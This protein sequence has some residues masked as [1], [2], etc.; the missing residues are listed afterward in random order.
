S[1]RPLRERLDAGERL[2]AA[3][4]PGRAGRRLRS[5]IAV[6]DPAI[7]LARESDPVDEAFFCAREIRRLHAESPELRYRDFAILLRS[8]TA[9]GG[10]FEEALRALGLPYEVRG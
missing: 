6:P 3:T 7:V 5:E 1:P 4:Q 10:P 9:L 2:L 8:T